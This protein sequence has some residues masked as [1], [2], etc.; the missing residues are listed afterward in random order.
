MDDLSAEQLASLIRQKGADTM[1]RVI[2]E[3]MP[4]QAEQGWNL[5]RWRVQSVP[6]AV[7]YYRIDDESRITS[8][9]RILYV[10][11][12]ASERATYEQMAAE[13][14]APCILILSSDQR[15]VPAGGRKP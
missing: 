8:D 7:V 4:K 14:D 15:P 6:G 12:S 2:T 3:G 13:M 11:A 1:G 9:T 10:N 5:L